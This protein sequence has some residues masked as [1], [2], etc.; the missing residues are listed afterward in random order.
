MDGDV[1]GTMVMVGDIN[2]V[3]GAMEGRDWQKARTV[4]VV[5][6]SSVV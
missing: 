1:E 3:F 2:D 4:A 6:Q 5:R